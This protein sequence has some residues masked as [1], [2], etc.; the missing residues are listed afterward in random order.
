MKS[1]KQKSKKKNILFF[2]ALD[3]ALVLAGLY[4]IFVS[5]TGGMEY[6]NSPDKRI[7]NA[8]VI[9]VKHT[10]E[11]D[12][13]GDI[14]SEKWAATLRYT[15]DGKEYT[16][17]KTYSTETYSGETVQ[18][19][20]YKTSKGEYKVSGTSTFGFVISASVLLFGAIGLTTENKNRK[21]GKSNTAKK[22]EKQNI[23]QDVKT[24]E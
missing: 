6:V 21:K 3:I 19:E 24:T 5:L 12:D 9:S 18:I 20:V 15:V 13:D 8:E 17:K 10:Y 11:K 4:G 16:T 2:L 1:K 22:N 23:K 7:I 14:T